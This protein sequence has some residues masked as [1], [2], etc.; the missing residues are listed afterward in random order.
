LFCLN[1]WKNSNAIGLEEEGAPFGRSIRFAHIHW[2]G[3]ERPSQTHPAKKTK[4]FPIRRKRSKNR[5]LYLLSIYTL[6]SDILCEVE[7][8]DTTSSASDVNIPADNRKRRASD[9]IRQ[10]PAR[11]LHHGIRLAESKGYGLNTFVT[12]CF[13]L[14]GC[15]EEQTDKAFQKIRTNY[16]KWITRP[17]KDVARYKAPPTFVWVIENKDC[18]LNAHWMV[19]VPTTR[20]NEFQDKVEE[21]LNSATGIIYS[22]KA[23]DIKQVTNPK[24]LEKY[25]LKG[26]FPT[27]ARDFG[28]N[29]EYQG[30]VTGRR[31]GHSKNIGPVQVARMRKQGKFP[32]AIRW[33]QN[34]YEAA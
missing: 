24:G 5:L 14:T 11:N 1:L 34:K 15:P 12:F 7:S 13:S 8:T 33:I 32:R 17:S 26:M 29:P 28:I 20:Q 2:E 9:Y 27:V 22:D 31:I 6:L 10:L 25:M 30:W 18:C 16:G 4:N 3:V 23:I 21:W 19:H